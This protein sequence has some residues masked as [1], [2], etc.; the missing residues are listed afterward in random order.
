MLYLTKIQHIFLIKSFSKL[1]IRVY[2][3]NLIIGNYKI[4]H[5][6][7]YLVLFFKAQESLLSPLL[8]DILIEVLASAIRQ[9]KELERKKG[10]SKTVF[11]CRHECFCQNECQSRKFYRIIYVYI[12]VMYI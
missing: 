10:R 4:L 1:R 2:F 7:L 12:Y 9:E 11:I 5:F 6:A 8:F 3:F